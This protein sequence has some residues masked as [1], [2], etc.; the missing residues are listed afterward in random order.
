MRIASP[1]TSARQRK[2]TSDY[3]NAANTT[4][5]KGCS[6]YLFNSCAVQ[7]RMSTEMVCCCRREAESRL[8]IGGG[9]A[10]K[11]PCECLM[12]DGPFLQRIPSVREEKPLDEETR[13][14]HTCTA[15][16][17]YFMLMLML[18][19]S[20]SCLKASKKPPEVTLH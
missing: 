2:K 16:L 9:E 8:R 18:M 1:R 13:T 17:D 10:Q 4:N 7:L 11:T 19:P 12:T 15:Q 5:H 20:C 3:S 6:T 14:E